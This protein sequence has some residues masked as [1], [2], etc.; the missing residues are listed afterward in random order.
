MLAP[1]ALN[2]PG[3][4]RTFAL[5]PGS[6][7]IDI[8]TPCPTDPITNATLATD[9]RGVSRPQGSACDSGSFESRGFTTG[10]PTGNNQTT[11]IGTA[12][13]NP[14]G[15]TVSDTNTEPVSGGQVT[16]T[17]TPGMGGAS[18]TF[19]AAGGCTLTSGTVAVCPVN[20]MSIV[21]SPSFTANA[22]VGGF[23][24]IAT[25]SG[26]TTPAT[27]TETNNPP[28][29]PQAYL[30]TRAADDVND[31]NCNTVA[32]GGCTLRQAVNAAN[33]TIGT[34][35]N[36]ITFAATT[37]GVPITLGS[38]LTL[39]HA[40]TLTGNGATNT[41]IQASA[42]AQPLNAAY[43]VFDI[44]SGSVTVNGVTIRNGNVGI[45]NRGGTR[46]AVTSRKVAT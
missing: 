26:I 20:A 5:L 30:V 24:I 37:N 13:T 32:T 11:L 18:A 8:L 9:Q 40:A 25:A 42:S 14:V 44:T 36:M 19:S 34:G 4:T 41:L 29:S 17:I 43:D 27:F 28:A 12:Y 10:M 35:T 2:A 16:F 22:T 46:E 3:T 15:L 33:L 45:H 39:S 7:A 6:P 38:T 1:L 31:A 21:T 23:T